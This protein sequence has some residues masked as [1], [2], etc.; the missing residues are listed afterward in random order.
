MAL[1]RRPHF[2]Q[3]LF[4]NHIIIYDYELKSKTRQAALADAAAFS[5]HQ[6]DEAMLR[7]ARHDS[8]W[9]LGEQALGCSEALSWRAETQTLVSY[10]VGARRT[11]AACLPRERSASR[12]RPQRNVIRGRAAT[13]LEVYRMSETFTMP[14]RRS[15]RSNGGNS[16][17]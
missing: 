11:S 4:H 3:I 16:F 8:W 9:I 6:L 13:Q 1:R 2:L 7:H 14:V 12:G 10:W 15:N 5:S 17:G